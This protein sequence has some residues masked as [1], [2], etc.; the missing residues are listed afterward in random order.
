MP[1]F[2]ANAFLLAVIGIHVRFLLKAYKRAHA[3]LTTDQTVLG[4]AAGDVV[5][6]AEPPAGTVTD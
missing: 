3:G 5:S 1:E 2:L 4:G 6:A